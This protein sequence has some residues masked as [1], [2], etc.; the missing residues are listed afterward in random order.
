[1]K[2]GKTGII[3]SVI[4]C[5]FGLTDSIFSVE[6][7]NAENFDPLMT[8]KLLSGPTSEV[9]WEDD[10]KFLTMKEKY[11]CPILMGAYKTVLPDPLPGEESNVHLA[12]RYICGTV[13]EPNKVFSQNSVAGPYTTQRGYQ[14]GPTYV[15]SSYTETISGGVCKIASTLYNVAIL[16]NLAIVE[17]HTHSMPVP[18]VPYGQDATVYYG[19]RDIKFMNN[20]TSPVLIWAEGIDNVLYIGFYGRTIPPEVTWKHEV[21]KVFKAPVIYKKNG[22]LPLNEEKLIHEG[23]DGVLI[24]S[25]IIL[26]YPD[27]TSTEKN[28]G[29]RYYAPLAHIKEISGK[30]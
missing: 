22:T 13:L 14:K 8:G 1:V 23:M 25:W 28:L 11:D 2:K 20:T 7:Q 30:S 19:S 6:S 24:N 3:L 17:R 16:S 12:A 29:K 18:Y 9:P 21:I 4:I 26:T 10:E 5:L 27:G 15:G